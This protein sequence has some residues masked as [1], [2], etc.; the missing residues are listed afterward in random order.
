MSTGKKLVYP[1]MKMEEI[2]TNSN[3]WSVK[4]YLKGTEMQMPIAN[5]AC[6]LSSKSLTREQSMTFLMFLLL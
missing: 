1:D 5:F 6:T 2:F 4:K 3:A